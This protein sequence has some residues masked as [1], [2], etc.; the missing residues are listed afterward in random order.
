M[1]MLQLLWVRSSAQKHP[2]VYQ[3]E[4]VRGGNEARAASDTSDKNLQNEIMHRAG[5]N[6]PHLLSQ[7]REAQHELIAFPPSETQGTS[8]WSSRLS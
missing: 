3:Q 4:P 8:L 7:V 6:N 1:V 2:V 5:R